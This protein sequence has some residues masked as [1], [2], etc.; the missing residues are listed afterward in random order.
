M[1]A[2]AAKGVEFNPNS[3][4]DE[5]ALLALDNGIPLEV[6]GGV[7]GEVKPV[8]DAALQ[9]A[10]SD[11]YAQLLKAKRKAG[12]SLEQATEVVERQRKTDIEQGVVIAEDATPED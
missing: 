9:E 4:K 1:D 2:L 5:L 3:K 11:H 7:A 10:P 8:G 12:L 6:E